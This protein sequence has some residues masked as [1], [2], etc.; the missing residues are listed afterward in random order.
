MNP[1]AALLLLAAASAIQAVHNVGYESNTRVW[2]GDEYAGMYKELRLTTAINKWPKKYMDVLEG[3]HELLNATPSV[4]NMQF[5]CDFL[6]SRH[7]FGDITKQQHHQAIA[8]KGCTHELRVLKLGVAA[9]CSYVK[10]KGGT[11]GALRAILQTWGE[12]SSLFRENFNISIAVID[13]RIFPRC[14]SEREFKVGHHRPQQHTGQ[15]ATAEATWNREC[16]P[17]YGMIDRL[18]DFS[19]WRS[20]MGMEA[21]LW[22]LVL[23]ST[24][25]SS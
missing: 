18:S 5:S 15:G 13:V 24:H 7:M 12:V 3:K 22:H 9:D 20:K 19:Q 14:G 21:G 2:I 6:P 25:P 10:R 17:S 11:D 8:A 23:C 1:L 16:S 4:H